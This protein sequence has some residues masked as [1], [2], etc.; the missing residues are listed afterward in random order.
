MASLADRQHIIDEINGLPKREFKDNRA[1]IIC[2]F[3][4]DTNPSGTVSL[5][6]T[7]SR[8]ALGWFRCWSC[9]KSVSWN[10]LA[11]QIGLRKLKKTRESP[12]DYAKPS[13]FRNNLLGDDDEENSKGAL[14]WKEDYSKLKFKSNWMELK[15]WRDVSLSLLDRVGARLV[16]HR[17]RKRY[18][19]WLPVRVRGKLRGYVLA[20]IEKPKSFVDRD[21]KTVVPPSYLNAPG[22]WSNEYGL[23]Y[24]DYAVEMAKSKGIDTLV[25]C[26]GP[27]D[28]LRLLRY[29][30]PAVS[31]LG[32]LN[33]SEAKR[34]TIERSGINN[35]ILFM[36]GDKAGKKAA[37]GIYRDVKMHFG[38]KV[39]RTWKLEPDADPFSCSKALL[40]LVR[41]K[42][43][44]VDEA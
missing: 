21:G 3:H 41:S 34:M 39:I 29:G 11:D 37:R 43:V 2:P 36:D 18:Y 8:V 14:G 15:H 35:L 5:D 31:V 44:Y 16:Y 9:G 27:R 4:N 30:I 40:R 38:T 7:E 13:S 32:A 33:W 19:V 17:E 22:K 26:E 6:E 10:T 1:T 20:K 42:L 25:L 28:A 12:D 23:I 24:F